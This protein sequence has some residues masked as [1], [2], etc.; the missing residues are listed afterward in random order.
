MSRPQNFYTFIILLDLKRI[1]Q[2]LTNFWM[3]VVKNE[4]KNIYEAFSLD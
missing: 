1:N 4:S 2:I 3:P